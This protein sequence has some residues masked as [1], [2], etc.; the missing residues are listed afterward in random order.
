MKME[1]REQH[2]LVILVKQKLLAAL[3]LDV[4][5][6]KEEGLVATSL[7]IKYFDISDIYIFEPSSCNEK[8]Y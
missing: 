1:K 4:V 5:E 2:V 7:T 3:P 6:V 8:I